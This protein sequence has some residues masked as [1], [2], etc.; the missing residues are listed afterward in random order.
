MN[1]GATLMMFSK[2]V[3]LKFRKENILL[4][5][6]LASEERPG[7]DFRVTTHE[8]VGFE[9]SVWEGEREIARHPYH[10]DALE[11]LLSSGFLDGEVHIVF[12]LSAADSGDPGMARV[13]IAACP[14]TPDQE[15]LLFGLGRERLNALGIWH[16]P[17]GV[18]AVPIGEHTV[19]AD[20]GILAPF[21]PRRDPEHEEAA[22]R[23]LAIPVLNAIWFGPEADARPKRPGAERP[24]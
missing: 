9:M 12:K 23:R 10:K 11:A 24:R 2:P 5:P 7:A 1:Q 17:D 13:A 8:A 14:T 22:R 19:P 21:D 3:K 20:V 15:D 18:R 4:G 6:A 16:L